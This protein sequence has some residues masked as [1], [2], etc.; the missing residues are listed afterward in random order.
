MAKRGRKSIAKERR[1]QILDAFH[2]CAVRSGLEKAS[3]REVA[4]EAGLPVS[5]LHHFFKNRDEMVGELVKRIV[6]GI[7]EGHRDETAG[8]KDPSARFR[9]TIDYLFSPKTIQL[10][11][12]SLFYDLWSSAHRSETVRQ[13]FQKQIRNQRQTFMD[14]LVETGAFPDIDMAEMKD[15]ANIVIAL[16]E[17][18]YYVM[19]MDGGNVSP[20]RMACL[21]RRFLELYAEDKRRE[22][23]KRATGS[24]ASGSPARRGR[25]KHTTKPSEN[26]CSS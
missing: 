15:I 20:K 5:N 25:R 14:I 1:A 10:Q 21:T 24:K 16:V 7:M 18:S 6:R 13:I 9:R 4:E 19:D 26:P 8:V 22:R 3:L 11:D 23:A 2:R 17:G 12:G